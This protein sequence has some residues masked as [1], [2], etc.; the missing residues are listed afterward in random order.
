MSYSGDCRP[1]AE[2][3]HKGKD[4]TLLIHECTFQSSHQKQAKDKMHSTL[5][6][7]ITVGIKM[8]AVR[9]TMT[10][11]SQRYAFSEGNPKNRQ[12]MTSENEAPHI[13][14][15]IDRSGVMAV[16]LLKFRMSQLPKLPILSPAFNYGVC[17][18]K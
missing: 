10:H 13:R 2:L 9:S 4:S 5:E 14:D 8:N 7:A 3:I 15:Y 18:E 1:S 12:R 11:F 16:D 17:E 6:E